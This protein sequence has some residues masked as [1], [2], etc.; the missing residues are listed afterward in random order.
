MGL[1]EQKRENKKSSVGF[2][3]KWDSREIVAA[4]EPTK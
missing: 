4:P 1:N 3:V 2:K